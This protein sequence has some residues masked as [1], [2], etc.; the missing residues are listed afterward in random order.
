MINAL[1][2]NLHPY[3]MLFGILISPV[4]YFTVKC[5]KQVFL[6]FAILFGATWNDR[7][8]VDIYCGASTQMVFSD[9]FSFNAT[10]F[11]DGLSPF[12]VLLLGLNPFKRLCAHSGW[13]LRLLSS[14]R[15][16]LPRTKNNTRFFPQSAFS[17]WRVLDP[18]L[19]YVVGASRQTS[20]SASPDPLSHSTWP[21]KTARATS[22]ASHT[23]TKKKAT[24]RC[25][26]WTHIITHR[27]AKKLHNS[28]CDPDSSANANAVF[29][30]CVSN[31]PWLPTWGHILSGLNPAVC[32]PFICMEVAQLPL[33]H[34]LR[35]S[36]RTFLF[37]LLSRIVS[38]VT[39]LPPSLFLS[40]THPHARTH[41]LALL[42]L[43]QML[44]FPSGTP[45]P[46][47][48]TRLTENNHSSCHPGEYRGQFLLHLSAG[49]ISLHL[50]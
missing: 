7:C 14:E 50:F 4:S 33:N 15:A 27:L 49:A 42:G 31:F 36:S 19:R 18:K 1:I 24:R 9:F 26:W 3:C 41:T 37:Y 10:L 28:S 2:D 8:I 32:S 6:C 17:S 29:F 22:T 30:F 38:T 40:R 46:R 20:S 43:K 5:F 34:S 44:D 13:L 35:C 47:R 39:S 48:C 25:W 21:D 45:T 16:T 23:H 11:R 12:A